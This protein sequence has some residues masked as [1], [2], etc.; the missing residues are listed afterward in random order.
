VWYDDRPPGHQPP[1]TSCD[2][3]RREAYRTGGRV[4]YGGGEGRDER[5]DRDDRDDRGRDRDRDDTCRDQDR[6]GRCDYSEGRYPGGGYPG[7]PRYPA[8]LPE[9]IWG[10]I[11][12]R[13]DRLAVGGVREWLG[14]ADVRPR[15]T[16]ADRDGRPEVVTWYDARGAIL[17]RWI[18]DTRDGRADRVAVY[19]DG[20][21]VRVV[22]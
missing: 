12:G 11:F 22:R 15:Y 5:Y 10:V 9:T 19:K 8:T 21:V 18:D 4:V 7:D 16:D 14:R 17:Q 2:A 6:D 1:P 3:A 20:R 13:G